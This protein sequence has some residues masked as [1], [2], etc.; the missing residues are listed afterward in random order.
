MVVWGVRRPPEA[1]E[2]LARW[3]LAGAPQLESMR[4]G[5]RDAVRAQPATDR[6]DLVE[7]LTIVV[8]ELAGNALRHGRPPTVVILQRSDGHL[9]V[10]VLDNDPEAVPAVDDDRPSGE[11][12]LGLV[13]AHRLAEE[14]GWYPTDTG[15]RVWARFS[16]A[17]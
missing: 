7:R 8:T 3:A 4:T 5:L 16:L 17:A 12:G 2:E 14:V 10:H 9:V 13:L 1:D 11:G 15:K 6:E